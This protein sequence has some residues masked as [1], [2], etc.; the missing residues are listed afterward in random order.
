MQ[1]AAT[2]QHRMERLERLRFRVPGCTL[3]FLRSYDIAAVD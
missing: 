2:P 3:C 1:L